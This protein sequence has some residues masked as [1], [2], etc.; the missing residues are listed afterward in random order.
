VASAHLCRSLLHDVQQ[1]GS[2]NLTLHLHERVTG[3]LVLAQGGRMTLINLLVHFTSA[4][5]HV[6]RGLFKLGLNCDV[7]VIFVS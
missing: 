4:V 7:V 2:Q 6:Q 1:L 5:Q 3:L